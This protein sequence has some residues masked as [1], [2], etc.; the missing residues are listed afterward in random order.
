[1]RT[2]L[3]LALGLCAALVG[4]RGSASSQQLAGEAATPPSL[5]SVPGPIELLASIEPVQP[6]SAELIV[7]FL[8][9]LAPIEGLRIL[10]YQIIE[11]QAAHRPNISPVKAVLWDAAIRDSVWMWRSVAT[12]IPLPE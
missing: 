8:L 4:C 2:V 9:R 3:F 7:H 12:L 11:A 10:Q 1:M 5:S 6:D